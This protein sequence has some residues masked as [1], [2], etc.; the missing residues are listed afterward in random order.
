M[1]RLL[2]IATA[3]LLTSTAA[4]SACTSISATNLVFGNYSGTQ[5]DSTSNVTVICDLNS[6]YRICLG[7]GGSGRSNSRKMTAGGAARLNYGMAKDAAHSLNWDDSTSF[8]TCP[9]NRGTG[10]A[11]T[12]TVYGRIPAAQNIALGSYTD[13]P[14]AFVYGGGPSLIAN[15]TVS[16]NIGPMCTISATNLAFG[17]Y[18][19]TTLDAVS[20]L[21]VTCAKATAYYV[22]LNEGMNPDG[23]YLPR[24]SG[25][26][27]AL[28]SYTLFQDAART[29][30]WGNTYNLDGVAG[31][32]N[33]I[34]QVLNVY[35]RVAAGQFVNPGAYSDTVIV[36]LTY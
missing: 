23:S 7:A 1:R 5:L 6:S 36:T 17:S 29:S 26:G 10:F 22:N 20:T 30:R 31:T 28:L 15:F 25:P 18:T 3:T 4:R 33:G 35:G 24:A 34:A 11:Q 2:A 13:N 8:P 12:Y 16:A 19:G 14:T 32:G 21:S 27:G 9:S